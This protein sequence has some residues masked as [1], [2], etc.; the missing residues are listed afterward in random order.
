MKDIKKKSTVKDIKVLDK[1]ANVSQR[2]KNA[3]IRTKA[4]AEQLGHND[5]S[6]Y[7]DDAGNSIMENAEA[8]VREAG[9][10]VGSY[11]KKANEKVKE[12]RELKQ[13]TQYSNA[14]KGNQ[15]QQAPASKM[16]ETVHKNADRKE[17]KLASERNT[18]PVNSKETIKPNASHPNSKQVAKQ[19]VIQSRPKETTKR[20]FTLSRLNE[21]AKRRFV[22]SR[23]KKRFSQAS[24]IRTA[25]QIPGKIQSQQKSGQLPSHRF[26]F[27][28][29]KKAAM[30][31]L[32]SG[33]AECAIKKPFGTGGKTVKEAAKGTIK[34]MK[35]TVKTAEH[36]AKATIKTSQAVAK[37]TIKTAVKSAQR[38]VHAAQAAA[39]ATA[40]TTKMAIKATV[41]AIKAILV[42]LKGLISLI[43]AGGWIAVVVILVICLAGFLLGSVYGVFFSNESSGENTPVMTVVVHQLNEEFT[44]ELE[45]IQDEN[46]HD[47]LDMSGSSTIGH[48]RE[49]LAVYAVKVTADPENGMEV[50]TLD[51]AKVEILRDI[52]WD[53]NKIDYWTETI[54]HEETV[55]TT[56]K[57][58]NETVET[59]TTT[60]TILHINIT[61]KSYSDMIAEYNFNA[62]Q[63]KM[64]N[65][66]MQDEYQELFMQLIGS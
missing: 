17:T 18:T 57:D 5:S 36:T 49:I 7:V 40:V 1:S 63:V 33:K 31:P 62:E 25:D 11:S 32:P 43:A 54:E 21:L 50:A 39:R 58:G 13:D 60:E 45:R 20:N 19:N 52:L 55:T 15:A 24:E 64:L 28:P 65:E 53:M 66:L 6:N 42:A 26:F 12:R 51:A 16:K 3:Y 8:I 29:A 61:T 59:V 35:K 47:T 30:Q 56:D 34:N 37:T 10:T 38:A 9:H 23:A 46:P 4:Q 2:M 27:Q 14:P 22:Q 44:S 41:A 48:W